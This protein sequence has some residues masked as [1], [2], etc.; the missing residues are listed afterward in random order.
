MHK[1][2]LSVYSDS[3]RSVTGSDKRGR[4]ISRAFETQ[5]DE[6]S[7]SR[8]RAVL[9]S[10]SLPERPW[11]TDDPATRFAGWPRRPGPTSS[12]NSPRSAHAIHVGTYIGSGKVS[13]L[14]EL[15]EAAAADVV[16]FDNDLSPGQAATSKA[17]GVKVLDVA[18]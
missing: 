17:L 15:V 3:K 14:G 10:V 11:P 12:A 7:V 1:C 13:E 18:S 4:T 2:S 5:R 8:E 16:V 9:V 6:F